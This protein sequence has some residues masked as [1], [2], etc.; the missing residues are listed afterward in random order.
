ML[1]YNDQRKV[2]PRRS[3][4]CLAAAV[5]FAG[6][7][8]LS[9]QTAAELSP[10]LD[11]YYPAKMEA[12]Y[13]VVFLAHN[14]GAKKEDWGNFGEDL[15]DSG[16]I[17]ASIGWTASRPDVDLQDAIDAVFKRFG[18]NADRERV[19]FIGGCHGA[20]KF[21]RLLFDAKYAAMVK[22][23]VFLSISEDIFI[24]ANHAPILAA[25]SLHDHLGQYYIDKTKA[26][27]EKSITEPK[28]VITLDSDAHGNE[29]VVSEGSREIV[30]SEIK[31][32]LK[33]YL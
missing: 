9:A 2:W 26:V 32:W 27:C 19:V 20:V 7:A 13:P 21:T 4:L 28:K 16:Y 18:A 11:L 14:G 30:R 29:M 6:A 31:A 10:T 3:A 24:D 33:R 5:L 17:V 12:S 15:A 1:D 8:E 23:L 25:H 22:A